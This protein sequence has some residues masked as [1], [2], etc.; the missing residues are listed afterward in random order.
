VTASDE[1]KAPV[2]PLREEPNYA[3][4][5]KSA[6]ELGFSKY[7]VNPDGS[8]T[9]QRPV[10]RAGGALLKVTLGTNGYPQVK[11]YDDNGRQ[12]TIPVHTIVLG[13][14]A[15][16]RPDGQQCRHWDDDPWNNRWRPGG[17]DESV[18]A[19]GNL[20][21]GTK[22]EN[23]EDG[24]RNGTLK[25]PQQLKRHPCINHD[26]CG[27]LVQNPGRRC[28]PCVR[29]AGKEAALMLNAG[30]PLD[31]VMQRFEYKSRTWAE[32]IA[33]EHGG[34]TG[35][36]PGISQQRR[37]RWPKRALATVRYRLRRRRD[38]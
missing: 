38:A 9:D 17:E 37:A 25:P 35:P 29:E 34:F 10:R 5:W 11:P 16:P 32:K 14:Y 12:R 18:R 31:E 27:G 6:A 2:I 22:A 19:G 21:W 8:G 24:W 26:R 33:R 1:R 4:M 20:F 15:G 36:L 30:R 13:V 3:V 23:V 7:E 28:L